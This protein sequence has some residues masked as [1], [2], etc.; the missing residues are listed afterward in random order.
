MYL[1]IA[2][3]RMGLLVIVVCYPVERL[4][5][6]P[7]WAMLEYLVRGVLSYPITP[8]ACEVHIWRV[9]HVGVHSVCRIPVGSDLTPLPAGWKSWI[10]QVAGT[11]PSSPLRVDVPL[12]PTVSKKLGTILCTMRGITVFIM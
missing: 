2:I 10:N 7:R 3:A 12:V 1:G 8:Q 6:F 5:L 4:G 11:L 9:F